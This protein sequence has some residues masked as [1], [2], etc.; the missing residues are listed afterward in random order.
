MRATVA[1]N[2]RTFRLDRG[3][4]LEDLSRELGAAG[5]PMSV[6]VLSK[7]ENGLRT[8]SVDDLVALSRVLGT[9]L[10]AL[11]AP[12]AIPD[13]LLAALE[14][15]VSAVDDYFVA[16][17]EHDMA[18]KRLASTDQRARE[19]ERAVS[20]LTA[21]TVLDKAELIELVSLRWGAGLAHHLGEV[22]GGED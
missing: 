3:W 22:L 2:I 13:E 11:V 9:T 5:Y 17:T 14:H 10:D 8:I 18:S 16:L 12:R 7:T 1:D 20:S 15:Y 19:A 6:K 21:K 4:R